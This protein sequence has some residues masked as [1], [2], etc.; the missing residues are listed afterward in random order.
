MRSR[1]HYMTYGTVGSTSTG[2]LGLLF[3]YSSLAL[4]FL[5]P[6]QAIGSMLTCAVPIG[7]IIGLAARKLSVNSWVVTVVASCSFL[8][9]A[10]GALLLGAFAGSWLTRDIGGGLREVYPEPLRY[11]FVFMA[12]IVIGAGI[13]VFLLWISSRRI[14]R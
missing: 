14:R 3:G 10:I 4:A 1:I 5:Q 7:I 8:A 12:A 2:I 11:Y 13:G 6:I 9:A